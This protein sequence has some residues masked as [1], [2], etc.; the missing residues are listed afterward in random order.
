MIER[1]WSNKM[2]DA[3]F[4]QVNSLIAL[5]AS[6]EASAKRMV[7]LKT[8]L[9]EITAAEAKLAVERAAF[10]QR[11][12]EIAKQIEVLEQRRVKAI[13]AE[14]SA[15]SGRDQIYARLREITEQDDTIKRQ[16]LARVGLAADYDHPLKGGNLPSWEAIQRM[17]GE[18][19]PHYPAPE[20]MA[21][22]PVEHTQI[23]STLTRSV[24]RSVPS[25]AARRRQQLAATDGRLGEE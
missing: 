1:Q 20:Q 19:D 10:D 23:G 25:A 12:A 16:V 2:D 8:V 21:A 18:P 9:D 7:E 11:A 13:Q 24:P 14:L 4:G 3:T 17:I 15:K 5:I 22:G 6:P